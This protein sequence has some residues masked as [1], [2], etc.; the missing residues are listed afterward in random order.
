MASPESSFLHKSDRAEGGPLQ[1]AGLVGGPPFMSP[2]SI[3]S[4]GMAV[5][6][7]YLT[8]DPLVLVRSALLSNAYG[9]M[10]GPS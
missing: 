8:V 10:V 6:P 4:I 9:V 7:D 3:S 1:S 2:H 5:L